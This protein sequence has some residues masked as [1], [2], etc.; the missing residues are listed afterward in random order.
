MC[1]LYSLWSFYKNVCYSKKGKKTEKFGNPEIF[2]FH[3]ALHCAQPGLVST[4]PS[5]V[6]SLL[7]SGESQ[8]QRIIINRQLS[9]PHI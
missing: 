8:L 1:E 2:H 9:K 3:V 4:P 6:S 7:R 5:I